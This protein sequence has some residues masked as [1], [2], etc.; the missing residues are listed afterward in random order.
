MRVPLG[1][2]QNEVG[3]SSSLALIDVS[4]MLSQGAFVFSIMFFA[5]AYPTFE[6]LSFQELV[7]PWSTM[8]CALPSGEIATFNNGIF[9][10]TF[11]LNT[12]DSARTL[13]TTLEIE[14]TREKH[15]VQASESMLTSL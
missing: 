7:C 5:G 2:R 13:L 15:D 4:A 11:D 14:R 8:L 9:C 6:I 3:A 12:T 1:P 10:S